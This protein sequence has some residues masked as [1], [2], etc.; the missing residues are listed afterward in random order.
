[1]LAEKDEP[2]FSARMANVLNVSIYRRN[3]QPDAATY[4]SPCHTHA[5]PY[6]YCAA[7]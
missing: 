3:F 4:T 5:V 7:G 1:M 6:G 2:V